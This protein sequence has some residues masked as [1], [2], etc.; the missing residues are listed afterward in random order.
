MHVPAAAMTTTALGL[1]LVGTAP[2]RAASDCQAAFEKW[3]LLSSTQVRANQSEGRGAC[4]PNEAAR[5]SLL[6][7]LARTRRVCGDQESDPS[8]HQT[9][10]LLNINLGFIASLSVCR[11]QESASA[12]PAVSEESEESGGWAPK[13]VPAPARAPERPHIAAPMPPPAPRPAP[14]APPR[15]PLPVA[16]P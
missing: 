4:I 12:P 7:A 16:P 15:A 9:R 14:V 10:T 8:V 2:A 1:L 6:D 13:A 5:R 11:G 3:A